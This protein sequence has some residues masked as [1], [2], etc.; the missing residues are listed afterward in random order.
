MVRLSPRAG[1]AAS[2]FSARSL[3]S[4]QARA[5]V[6]C[7][8][9]HFPPDHAKSSSCFAICVMKRN[10]RGHYLRPRSIR[11]I[12]FRYFSPRPIGSDKSIS[13]RY[14]SHSCYYFFINLSVLCWVELI[15][16]PELCNFLARS[17]D[18]VCI[19]RL[20]VRFAKFDVKFRVVQ[21]QSELLMFLFLD[22]QNCIIYMYLLYLY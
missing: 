3:H 12:R 17:F 8:R 20:H 21:R 11:D 1:G 2:P 16:V 4:I 19:Q 10:G 9:E 22:N 14:R 13:A 5:R 6:L 18:C 15:F 7:T